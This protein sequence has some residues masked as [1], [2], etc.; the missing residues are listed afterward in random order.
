MLTGTEGDARRM[1]IQDSVWALLTSA[2][3]RFNH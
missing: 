3:F 2:E 1:I